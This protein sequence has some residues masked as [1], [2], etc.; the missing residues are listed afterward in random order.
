VSDVGEYDEGSIMHYDVWT[1]NIHNGQPTMRSRRGRDSLMGNR[2]DLSASDVATL[3]A[4]YA[5]DGVPA[6]KPAYP[7]GPC[8]PP[9]A[10]ASLTL[11]DADTHLPIPGYERLTADATIDL[12]RFPARRVEVRATTTPSVVGSVRLSLNGALYSG[13][14]NNPPYVLDSASNYGAAWT[15][16]VGEHTITATP[17]TLSW[18]AGT[19]GRALTVRFSVAAGGAPSPGVQLASRASGKCLDVV[20]A[21]RSPGADV[22]VWSC[23]GDENQRW[24]LPEP[25]ATGEVRVFGT[26]CLDAAGGTGANG[27]PIITWS[28]HGGANQRWTRT[29][30]G[31][32]R[33]VSDRCVDV[34]GAR[35]D[36]GAALI[37]WDCHGGSNQQWTAV[38]PAGAT[39][40]A[41]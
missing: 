17:Y 37:L 30:A 6:C 41:R 5:P 33:G 4:L 38:A 2:M 21:S 20:G 31:E 12:S 1:T 29:A 15:P 28:C 8:A 19:A 18:A 25:G 11:L 10:V 40:A 24:T 9:M 39:M 34:V 14:D 16:T 3:R 27:D 13:Y 23:H 35:T 22:I 36:D 26:L 7:G 32:L